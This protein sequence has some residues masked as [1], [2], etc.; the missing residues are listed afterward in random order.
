MN[1]IE[2]LEKS[3][4]AT[5]LL[6]LLKEV[7]GVETDLEKTT[8]QEISKKFGELMEEANNELRKGGKQITNG[9]RNTSSKSNTRSGRVTKKTKTI[10]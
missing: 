6:Q 1:K 10:N 3:N 9:K 7:I 8:W 4:K 5:V 2:V